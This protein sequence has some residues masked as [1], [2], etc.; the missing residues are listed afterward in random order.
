M[1]HCSSMLARWLVGAGAIVLIGGRPTV[2]DVF[3]HLDASVP[4]SLIEDNGVITWLDQSGNG[5]NATDDDL[6]GVI[7]FPNATP[8]PTGLEGVDFD[9]SEARQRMQLLDPTDAAT[10]L[11]QSV[12]EP[13]GFSIFI[14]T[15]GEEGPP[16]GWNDVI[17]NSTAVA[18][19]F[20][21]RWHTNNGKLQAS[22]DNGSVNGTSQNNTAD[23]ANYNS[24]DAFVI[25]I[26]YDPITNG[27]ELTLASTHN[28]YSQVFAVPPLDYSNGDNPL[29]LGAS[30]SG[31]RYFDGKIGEVLIYDTAL[32][33]EE[34]ASALAALG[35]KWIGGGPEPTKFIQ[36]DCN[37]DGNVDIA[38]VLCLVKVLFAGFNLLDRSSPDLPCA[39]DGGNVAI[40]D[41]S[42]N[43]AIDV[44]DI[45]GL[46]SS[47]FEMG[48]P[49]GPTCELLNAELSCPENP[50]CQ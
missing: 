17:G 21:M 14:A 27:G 12:A 45:V 43:E 20:L 16:Q 49:P 9:A 39:T 37:D 42:G 8:F 34:F 11:D 1:T 47:L 10:L 36:G 31:N 7:S 38:D 23:H 44:A 48:P 22:L 3:V 25:A 2:A 40:L 30:T 46:A 33:S 19:G 4:N 50:G 5:R 29:W 41:N 6:G 18:N 15:Q 35:E 24:R 32:P 28:R 13:A 26:N